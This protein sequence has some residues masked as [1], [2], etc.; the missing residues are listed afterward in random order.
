MSNVNDDTCIL[1]PSCHCPLKQAC[2]HQQW[3]QIDPFVNICITRAT[4]ANYSLCTSSHPIDCLL[5]SGVMTWQN[6]VVLCW[7]HL[8]CDRH[9]RGILTGAG[10]ATSRERWAI[11]T[12][13]LLSLCTTAAQAAATDTQF[14]AEDN[15]AEYGWVCDQVKYAGVFV[16][17]IN[18]TL[19]Y[20][21]QQVD[22]INAGQL[23]VHSSRL[24]LK[25]RW[26]QET[27]ASSVNTYFPYRTEKMKWGSCALFMCPPLV[28]RGVPACTQTSCEFV[29]VF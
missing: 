5:Q 16:L 14:G 25:F 24:R 23:H 18:V 11:D 15:S 6:C 8:E 22:V 17:W 19:I 13:P 29:C 20:I 3:Q 2:F 12:H 10:I 27:N 28:S 1:S 21:N 7:G 26:I 4:Q 9:C